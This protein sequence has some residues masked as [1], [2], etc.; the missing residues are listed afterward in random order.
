MEA[1]RSEARAFIAAL[2]RE[3]APSLPGTPA[4]AVPEG[5][6]AE[7]TAVARRL[8]LHVLPA[9]RRGPEPAPELL[10]LAAALVVDEHPS[11]PRWSAAERRRLAHWV[12][13]LIEHRG[14]DG[15]QD[16]VRELNRG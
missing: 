11:A 2:V 7:V 16:L 6:V 15:V 3:E 4:L 13:V 9:G 1:D 14:E 8:A 12:A 5:S 10:E